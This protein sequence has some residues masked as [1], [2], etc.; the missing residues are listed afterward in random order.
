MRGRSPRQE[1][2]THPRAESR[3]RASGQRGP[4]GLVGVVLVSA[5]FLSG[6]TGLLYEVVWTRHLTL[7]LGTTALAVSTVLAAFMAGLGLGAWIFGRLVDRVGR[8][9]LTYGL[10]E[11]GVATSALAL[12][13]IL[14]G[15]EPLHR[16]AWESFHPSFPAFSAIRFAL[17]SA[18][19][20]VPT[21]LMG[22]TL[23][24]LVAHFAR[25]GEGLGL[26]AGLLYGL[27]TSGAVLGAGVTG[28]LLL[29][30]LGMTRT[31][32]VAIGVNAGIGLIAVAL[33]L[34]ERRSAARREEA[35]ETP[36]GRLERPTPLPGGQSRL[37]F[38]LGTAALSGFVAL[39]AEVAWT[40]VLTLVLGSSTYAF[41]I[42]LVTFLLGLALGSLAM[43]RLLR[44]LPA[45]LT[46][47]A[48]LQAG[49]GV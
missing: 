10:L 45:T 41:T 4:D 28:F 11:L 12:P 31:T 49:I 37:A 36:T 17:V 29:P 39:L 30:R 44:H 33:G 20:L 19:L 43:A 34:R 5:F 14:P 38:V 13:A 6:A 21:T 7:L 25:P 3:E 32:L 15:L 23:P 47:L 24:V 2:T 35:A 8:A 18:L 26:R 9:V 42:M 1:R 46:L 22:G 27:N 40:R 48:G 16:W